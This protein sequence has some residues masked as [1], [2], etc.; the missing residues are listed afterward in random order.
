M[1]KSSAKISESIPEESAIQSSIVEEDIPD[2][3]IESKEDII[4]EASYLRQSASSEIKESIAGSAAKVAAP[5]PKKIERIREKIREDFDN[6]GHETFQSVYK[7]Q[8]I[9]K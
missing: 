6:N 5:P 9:K 3:V 2:N 1:K 4:S 8:D 7:A